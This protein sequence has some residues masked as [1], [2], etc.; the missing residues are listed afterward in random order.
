LLSGLFNKLGGN[1]LNLAFVVLIFTFYFSLFEG[2]SFSLSLF[3]EV[4]LSYLP[5]EDVDGN[6]IVGLGFT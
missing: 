3:A 4:S 5:F 2:G 1:W 6:E